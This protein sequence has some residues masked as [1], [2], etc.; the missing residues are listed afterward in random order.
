MV[1]DSHGIAML[2][3]AI[4]IAAVD[5]FVRPLVLRGGSA[6]L[7]PLLAFVAAF[8]GLQT[9]GFIGVFLGPIVAGL[10][11]ATVQIL[12]NDRPEPQESH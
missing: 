1:D 10:F 2:V 8:G 11:V 4:V 7:H 12:L 6:N 5:N 3:M 9:F